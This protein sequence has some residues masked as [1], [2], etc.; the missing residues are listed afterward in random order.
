MSDVNTTV[1]NELIGWE[2]EINRDEQQYVRVEGEFPFEVVNMDRGSFP[3]SAKLPPCN[4]ATLT[5]RVRTDDGEATVFTDLI[6]CR[7]L[8]WKLSEFFRSIGQKKQGET[9][10]MNWNTVV[11]ARGMA[12]FKPRKYIKDGEERE[13]NNV[14]KFLD[15]DASKMEGFKNVPAYEELPFE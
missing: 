15:Y 5:L 14:A 3:G 10:K 11:G 12:Q 8:E 2:D 7:A 4:K 1:N 9:L 13:A 6:M